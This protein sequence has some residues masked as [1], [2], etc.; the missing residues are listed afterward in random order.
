MNLRRRL[1]QVRAA[2]PIL[3]TRPRLL[4]Q[5]GWGVVRGRLLGRHVLR[6]L[7]LQ[8]NTVCNQRCEGCFAVHAR[9]RTREMLSLD[10]IA[11]VWRQVRELGG[12]QGIITGGEP[13][14]RKDLFDVL[15]ALQA[16][17]YMFGMTTNTLRIDR[18]YLRELQRAGLCYLAVSLNALDP[19]ENDRERGSPGHFDHVMDVLGWAKE[20]RMPAGLSTIFSHYNA[21]EFERLAR[22]AQ[23]REISISPAFAVSLGRWADRQDVRLTEDD[24]RKLTE[25]GDRYPAVRPELINN[26]SGAVSCPGGTEKVFVTAYGEVTTCQLNPV[27]FGNVRAESIA[28]IRDRM[29][30]VEA[31]RRPNPVCVISSDPDY[32]RDYVEP[33]ARVEQMPVPLAQHPMASRHLPAS[34][35][36]S[37]PA[38]A[39]P[40][41]EPGSERIRLPVLPMSG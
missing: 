39:E 15:S 35:I 26:L 27:S 3:A 5:I 9:D 22:F 13:T 34:A 18:P 12:F 11:D 2:W 33:V 28:R 37:Q 7:E 10:E 40:V 4:P 16:R 20:I 23:E 38:A 24:Y 8:V 31:F 32:V 17:Q 36:Q 1:R 25:I 30:E 29:L 21:A 6:Y 41:R 19:A 14:M